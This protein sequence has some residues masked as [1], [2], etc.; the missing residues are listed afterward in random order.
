L[1]VLEFG[2]GVFYHFGGD[3]VE[4]AVYIFLAVSVEDAPGA[5]YVVSMIWVSCLGLVRI[6]T[7]RHALDLG[8]A[9]EI[10]DVRHVDL[11]CWL[12]WVESGFWLAMC[13]RNFHYV[14]LGERL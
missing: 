14:R 9:I 8:K 7:L 3:E 6:R 1:A 2:V 5:A 12:E 4:S 10:R 13:S 11:R